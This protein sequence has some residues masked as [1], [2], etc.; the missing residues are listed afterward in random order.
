MYYRAK[1]VEEVDYSSI[2]G[3]NLGCQY[4]KVRKKIIFFSLNNLKI[5]WLK[6]FIVNPLSVS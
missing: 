4:K 1:R 5:V 6:S 3:I 2:L